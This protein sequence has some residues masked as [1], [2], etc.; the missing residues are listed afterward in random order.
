M[1]KIIIIL[2]GISIFSIPSV[3]NGQLKSKTWQRKDGRDRQ[4]YIG[5][6]LYEMQR[7]IHGMYR[8]YMRRDGMES[9]QYRNLK[10]TE[11]D[12]ILESRQNPRSIMRK[13]LEKRE[14]IEFDNFSALKKYG[15]RAD[16]EAYIRKQKLSAFETWKLMKE[17]GL[18][19]K[20]K[21]IDM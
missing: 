6:K 8:N 12:E 14:V 15:S 21:K 5:N 11:K 3:A 16:K 18:L 17:L 1:Y 7:G 19:D 9:S 10:R 2:I 4:T 13:K 20:S